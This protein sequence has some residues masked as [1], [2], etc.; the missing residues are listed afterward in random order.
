MIQIIL[1]SFCNG[2]LSHLD[3]WKKILNEFYRV[4]KPQGRLWINVFGYSKFRKLPE[5][6]N[7]KFNENDKQNINKILIIEKWNILKIRYI[8]NMFL[9]KKILFKKDS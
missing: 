4:L 1:T 2:I 6:I 3:N 7:R 9:E 5:N 8:E